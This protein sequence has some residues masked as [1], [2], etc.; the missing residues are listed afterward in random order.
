MGVFAGDTDQL[1]WSTGFMQRI[2]R[3]KVWEVRSDLF[4]ENLKCQIKE[5]IFLTEKSHWRFWAR[6][7]HLHAHKHHQKH[8][9]Y[10]LSTLS[11]KPRAGIFSFSSHSN[12]KSS[13]H[14]Y[15]LVVIIIPVV[16]QLGE[17][18]AEGWVSNLLKDH[19]LGKWRGW[20]FGLEPSDSRAQTQPLRSVSGTLI[21]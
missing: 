10:L 17:I 12:P 21:L 1:S 4:V 14:D 3:W 2:I 19:T 6:E 8:H 15:I 20:G 13:T 9:Q 5:L 7:W 18:L 16:I 11:V